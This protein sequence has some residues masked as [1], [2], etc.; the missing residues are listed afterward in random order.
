M[1]TY[2]LIVLF[3]VYS[4]KIFINELGKLTFWVFCPQTKLPFKCLKLHG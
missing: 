3:V 2:I 4:C 1:H